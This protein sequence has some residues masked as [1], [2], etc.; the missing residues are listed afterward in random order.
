M[1]L[2][3]RTLLAYLDS[4]LPT[5]QADELEQKI[6]QSEPA[7]QLIARIREVQQRVR[8]GAPSLHGRGTGGD[9]NSVA[10]YLDNRLR[11]EKTAEIEKICIESDMQ[12]AEVAACHQILSQ[13][14][15]KP[16][17]S[18]HELR[19]RLYA[20]QDL[21]INE[22]QPH[23]DADFVRPAAAAAAAA[24]ALDSGSSHGAWYYVL[25][26]ALSLSITLVLLAGGTYL[27]GGFDG[28][29]EVG[30]N[31]ADRAVRDAPVVDP[32]DPRP[33]ILVP[34][35]EKEGSEARVD[36]AAAE[37]DPDATTAIP[38]TQAPRPGDGD[39]PTEGPV[40]PPESPGQGLSGAGPGT[41]GEPGD[42]SEGAM[43]EEEA[44]PAPTT[45][46]R[47]SLIVAPGPIGVVA[48]V[49]DAPNLVAIVDAQN[50]D[51]SRV[52]VEGEIVTGE[53]Y[54]TFP[55]FES[56]V[57][58]SPFHFRF[59]GD[60]HW[61]FEGTTGDG[62]LTLHLEQGIVRIVADQPVGLSVRLN[63]HVEAIR[64][65]EPGTDLAIR[66][67]IDRLPGEDPRRVESPHVA[68]FCLIKGK[69]TLGSPT[70]PLP[71][72]VGQPMRWVEGVG[73]FALPSESVPA[74]SAAPAEPAGSPAIAETEPAADEERPARP[75]LPGWVDG[76]ERAPL[77]ESAVTEI[78]AALPQ[79]RSL[80][81]SLTELVVSAKQ[82][83][84]QALAAWA[85]CSLAYFDPALQSFDDPEQKSYWRDTLRAIRRD[86]P[87]SEESAAALRTAVENKFPNSAESV[88]S[89]ILGYSP[90]DLAAGAAADLV[91]NLERQELAIRVLAFL[92]LFQIT[93]ITHV[94]F[95]EVVENRRRTAVNRWR[96]MLRSGEIRYLHPPVP[97]SAAAV[98]VGPAATSD[99]APA[100]L[101][102]TTPEASE[103]RN[104]SPSP[105]AGDAPSDRPAA[106]QPL[107]PIFEESDAPPPPT[108][109]D[110]AETGGEPAASS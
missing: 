35:T 100:P 88:W 36:A 109:E 20:L 59:L 38:A 3:L 51:A 69:A 79:D 71:L 82:E 78:L 93:D 101:D 102:A 94:Y 97:A 25:V 106:E 43:T 32:V 70:P 16:L 37:S 14:L 77:E 105:A 66:V 45:V 48:N 47:P 107:P 99:E 44:P 92:N 13:I 57:Y 68:D 34:T 15:G 21:D 84:V 9:P 60:S 90:D 27:L 75:A 50:V 1:R 11:S 89:M 24:P 86:L 19:Q 61:G 64:F 4:N 87:L 56:A 46:G 22:G 55:L 10:E 41:A 95:P 63:G 31:G 17:Q 23:A 33:E 7:Q 49:P 6:R 39:A 12:L 8:L 74:E 81:L 62:T 104:A 26:G 110:G 53:S 80:K 2:T 54:V 103:D 40:P 108:A 52:P 83:E 65:E 67:S 29:E 91:A 72:T 18:P 85:L 76:E 5:D 58:A 42:A 96:N 30:R 28:D 98:G 73:I